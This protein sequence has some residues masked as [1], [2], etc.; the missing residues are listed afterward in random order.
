MTVPAKRRRAAESAEAFGGEASPG[1]DGTTGQAAAGVVGSQEQ[2][3]KMLA[4][5]RGLEEQAL[6]GGA[7][8]DADGGPGLTDEELLGGVLGTDKV[9][10]KLGG[11][12]R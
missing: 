5:M 10:R 8:G 6:A 11:S 12:R 4:V 2:R 9:G 1:G 7:L 3:S